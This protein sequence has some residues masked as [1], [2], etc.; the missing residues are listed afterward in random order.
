MPTT[1]SNYQNMATMSQSHPNYQPGPPVVV[2]QPNITRNIVETNTKHS[3]D[4][5]H[6]NSQGKGTIVQS[7]PRI[8][9]NYDRLRGVKFEYSAPVHKIESTY[10]NVRTHEHF[11]VT[12]AN[13]N[14]NNASSDSSSSMNT[15]S[16]STTTPN[17]SSNTS[18]CESAEPSLPSSP[19]NN[20]DRNTTVIA[21]NTSQNAEEENTNEQDSSLNASMGV[22]SLN[23]SSTATNTSLNVSL[24]PADSPKQNVSTSETENQEPTNETRVDVPSSS[25]NALSGASGPDSL[26]NFGLGL[27]AVLSLSHNEGSYMTPRTRDH[28]EREKR[29]S[30]TPSTHLQGNHSQNR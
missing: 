2:P 20:T 10:Q 29:H 5:I 11:P 1:Q 27:Q 12:V 28:R 3:L 17:T 26:L 15:A 4:L 16:V 8:G 13:F 25:H 23:E 14:A 7:V 18:T 22:L 9:E 30:L 19:D 21:G 6:F 24:P